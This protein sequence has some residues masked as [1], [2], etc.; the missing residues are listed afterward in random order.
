[1]PRR[2]KHSEA[3]LSGRPGGPQAPARRERRDAAENRQ[4]ILAA[5]RRLF[6][7]RGIDQTSMNEIAR[8]AGVGPGTLYR[9]FDHKGQLCEA[10]VF[11]DLQV[12]CARVEQTLEQE[13]ARAL[14]LAQLGWLLD[15]LLK[16]TEGHFP[17]LAAIQEAAVSPRRKEHFK[18]PFYAWLNRQLIQLL[19]RAVAQ[20][21]VAPLNVEVTADAIQAAT[22]PPLLAYQAEQRGLTHE[23]I[24]AALRHLYVDNLRVASREV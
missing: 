10:L 7:E 18:F 19:T 2:V 6:A 8:A 5:A 14:A 9:R 3:A 22:A 12:F 23:Q 11:D 24:G 13:G 15:E 4:H 16:M 20:G 17:L 1:M 21:E